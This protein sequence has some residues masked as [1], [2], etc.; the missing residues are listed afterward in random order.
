MIYSVRDI[1]IELGG[2]IIGDGVKEV[3]GICTPEDL[4]VNHVVFIRDE[5][6]YEKVREFDGPLCVVLGFK[7]SE[8]E[9]N[10]TY[11]VVED[12][13]IDRVFISLLYLFDEAGFYKKAPAKGISERAVVADGVRMGKGVVVGDYSVIEDG[14][15]VGD[16]TIIGSGCTIG[17]DTKIGR[18]CVIHP[19]VC[20]YPN[21]VIEDGVII[22]SGCVIG[23]DGFG[24]TRIGDK[25][26]KIPQIGGVYIERGVEIGANTTID[27]ATIG[28]TRIGENTKI[29]N[30]VQI[31]H[32]C[33]IGRNT[34]I[35][36]LCGISG[37][38]KIGNNVV[39]SGAVGIKDHVIIEDD[40]YIGAKAGV[41]EK[42]VKK[43]SRILGIPAIPFKEEMEFIAL[44]KRLKEMYFELKRLKKEREGK[45]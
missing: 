24:Y 18:E 16:E 13:E 19:N 1:A 33:E 36:A 11:I 21:T 30:M 7:P 44:K 39:I 5:K 25:N 40:V 3:N 14:V 17:R 32:N 38:V 26:V 43:G 15:S 27:R 37:S 8:L 41:M 34:I 42:V 9:T 6:I 20:I 12:K 29:D 35:C 10:F 22:H 31:A 4:K 2:E 45:S 23:A 28:Y